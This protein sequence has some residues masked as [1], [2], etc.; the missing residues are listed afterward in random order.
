MLLNFD[1]NIAALSLQR[2][3]QNMQSN[4]AIS[5]LMWAENCVYVF[6]A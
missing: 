1:V 5:S 3:S 6:F 2:Y 4:R